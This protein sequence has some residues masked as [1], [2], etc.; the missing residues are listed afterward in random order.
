[1]T[2]MQTLQNG[3]AYLSRLGSGVLPPGIER[4]AVAGER[5][6]PD[7]S[8]LLERARAGGF[9]TGL[10]VRVAQGSGVSLSPAQ[11]ERVQ[12]AA[13]VA[14][15]HGA[16]RAVLLIDGQELMLDVMGREIIGRADLGGGVSG[17][18][19]MVTGIDAVIR[20]PA[21]NEEGGAEVLPPPATSG[22]EPSL[23]NALSRSAT[24]RERTVD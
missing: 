7:F 10:P 11:L 1:M 13:D 24:Q 17:R 16:T 6:I 5:G 18:G 2:P 22:L 19:G 15:A 23:L 9:S 20:V 4:A 14:E 8:E 12:Q 3:S 21:A